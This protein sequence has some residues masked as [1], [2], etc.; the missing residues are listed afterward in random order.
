MMMPEEP[1]K[2]SD[3]PRNGLREFSIRLLK[4]LLWTIV[5]V[6]VLAV[7]AGMILPPLG[8]MKPKPAASACKS[9]LK[10][11]NRI[12]LDHYR[13]MENE[14]SSLSRDSTVSAVIQAI[15]LQNPSGRD[16]FCCQSPGEKKAYLAFPSPVSVMSGESIGEP[17]VPVLMCQPDCFHNKIGINVLYSDGMVRTIPR[18]EAEKLVSEYSPMPLELGFEAQPE[19]GK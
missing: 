12:I 19:E 7:L 13:E 4:I 8:R 2:Q 18:E 10:Q 3:S 6:A 11:A 5:I 14:D 1:E 15:I 17:P 16:L 9:Y